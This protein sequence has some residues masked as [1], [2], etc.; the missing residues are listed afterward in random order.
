MIPIESPFQVAQWWTSIEPTVKSR[1]SAT[2]YSSFLTMVLLL[3][4]FRRTVMSL[5]FLKISVTKRLL[6]GSRHIR[7]AEVMDNLEVGSLNKRAKLMNSNEADTPSIEALNQHQSSSTISDNIEQ[8]QAR[9]S[10]DYWKSGE[11]RTLFA[12]KAKY[13]DEANVKGV[14]ISRIELF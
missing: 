5:L 11:A 10:I 3:L 13:G 12:P 8:E 1:A 4:C 9:L 7:T 2:T 6:G 14:V